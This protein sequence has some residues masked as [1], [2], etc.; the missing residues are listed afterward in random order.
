MRAIWD[1]PINNIWWPATPFRYLVIAIFHIDG[2][3]TMCTFFIC[4]VTTLRT[5]AAVLNIAFNSFAKRAKY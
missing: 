1:A 5:K 3:Y 2:F 4:S